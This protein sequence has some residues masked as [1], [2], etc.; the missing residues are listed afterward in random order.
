[1]G[2]VS[3]YVVTHSMSFL[4][5][6]SKFAWSNAFWT[7]AYENVIGKQ[8]FYQKYQYHPL[9]YVWA[10]LNYP[11]V[12]PCVSGLHVTWMGKEFQNRAS[13]DVHSFLLARKL[14]KSEFRY[15]TEADWWH[16]FSSS[17]SIS[18]S[19]SFHLSLEPPASTS[20][21]GREIVETNWE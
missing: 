12:A 8:D 18:I 13:P 1:M 15:H 17:S 9:L 2:L 16:T 19:R 20:S 6:L 14:G 5:P 11:G 3:K 10:L 21:E 4:T 7:L